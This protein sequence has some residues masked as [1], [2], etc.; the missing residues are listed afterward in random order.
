HGFDPAEYS[1]TTT[2]KG[3]VTI[4]PGMSRRPH[5]C[6][7]YLFEKATAGVPIDVL[8]EE[9]AN[10]VKVPDAPRTALIGNEYGHH[11]FRNYV[12]LIR[13]YSVFFNPT[14][15]S[16]MPRCRAEAM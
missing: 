1:P 9:M 2:R 13:E 3:A 4:C 12:D 16:P 7:Y 11:R 15:L 5:Y 14:L 6:G 8:G 10:A